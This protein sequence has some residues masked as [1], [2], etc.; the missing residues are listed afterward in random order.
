MVIVGTQNNA[1]PVARLDW[2][3]HVDCPKCGR[4]NDLATGDHDPEYTVARAIFTNAWH[5][6]DGHEVTCIG[7]GHEFSIKTVEY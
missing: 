1:Q 7:C 5:E 4:S 6:L 3:L 2:S